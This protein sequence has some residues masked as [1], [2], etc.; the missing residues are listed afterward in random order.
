MADVHLLLSLMHI[1]EHV[2]VNKHNLGYDIK[3]K[4]YFPVKNKFFGFF[5]C[6]FINV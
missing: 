1:I 4:R 3:G 2:T 5:V 6:L